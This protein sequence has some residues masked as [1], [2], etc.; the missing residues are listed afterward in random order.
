MRAK[1][2]VCECVFVCTMSV[3]TYYELNSV[4][5]CLCV[6][7]RAGYLLVHIILAVLTCCESVAYLEDDVGSVRERHTPRILV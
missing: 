6:G 1:E 2:R 7:E 4:S 5:V 3:C